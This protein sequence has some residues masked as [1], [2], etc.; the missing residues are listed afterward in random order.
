MEDIK[1]EVDIKNKLKEEDKR[2]R[3]QTPD[4]V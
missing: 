1:E 4:E 2:S 3:I